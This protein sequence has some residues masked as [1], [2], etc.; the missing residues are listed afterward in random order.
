M[1]FIL[2]LALLSSIE[3]AMNAAPYHL[4]A[5]DTTLDNMD[6]V[7]YRSSDYMDPALVQ[8][9][10]FKS[11]YNTNSPSDLKQSPMYTMVQTPHES[12]IYSTPLFRSYNG[13]SNTRHYVTKKEE[14]RREWAPMKRDIELPVYLVLNEDEP[15]W[16]MFEE[17]MN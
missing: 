11:I 16:P 8:E 17:D 6:R 3:M 13:R 9:H 12:S 14:R 7:R 5:K 4:S 1:G 15:L 2:P 10:I